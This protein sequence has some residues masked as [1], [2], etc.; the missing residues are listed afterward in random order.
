MVLIIAAARSGFAALPV[1]GAFCSGMVCVAGAGA[2]EL[3]GVP[4]PF[5]ELDISIAMVMV[6]CAMFVYVARA[7]ADRRRIADP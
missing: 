5:S 4:L 2:A 7:T 6:L 1:G 3:S